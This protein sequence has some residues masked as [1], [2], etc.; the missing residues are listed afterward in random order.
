MG[1][2]G[3]GQ[4]ELWTIGHSN[5]SGERFIGLLKSFRI[6]VVVDVRS[7]P[8][9]KH[10]TH[11]S[12]APLRGLLAD[13]GLQYVFMGR[14]LGGRPDE[15]DLYD[16]E[17]RVLYGQLAETLRF[18]EGLSRLL[19]GALQW[20]VAMMC[21]EEDPRDCHRRLLITRALRQSNHRVA[22]R[23][24]CGDGS[25]VDEKQVSHDNNVDHQPALFEEKD[26]WRST[27]ARA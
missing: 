9:A 23:H 26:Q 18:R 1:E 6:D 21:S 8:Y 25:E 2:A 12:Q 17:G 14:E 13:A 27:R 4:V 7:Q 20:R 5:H 11:F 22:V 3:L 15:P 10:A 16:S 24:I 19:E